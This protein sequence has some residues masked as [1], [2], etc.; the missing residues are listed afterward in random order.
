MNTTNDKRMGELIAPNT[1]RFTRV[2]PGPIERVW[3][4]LVDPEKRSK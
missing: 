2:L 1:I 4:Y 3:S